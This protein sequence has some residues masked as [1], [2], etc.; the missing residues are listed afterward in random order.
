MTTAVSQVMIPL[1]GLL[2]QLQ[3]LLEELTD[4]QY[5]R[6]VKV[7]TNAT[8]GQHT[9]HI[10]E[11]FL[12]LN[13]GYATGQVNY[14]KRKRDYRIETSRACAIDSLTMV[15]SLLD[16][17][18]KALTLTVDYSN[19]NEV[20]GSVETNYSRELVY[21]LEHTVHHMALL[22]I[23]VNAVSTIVLP[24]EF[25]VAISTLKHRSACVQ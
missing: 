13:A 10:I 12:E 4:E 8:L 3:D 25:G 23:G 20:L 21:N 15:L 5:V 22:R 14:D 2:L 19:D 16:K 24:E 9:R 18:N 11:F 1:A 7:L 17:E 6:P